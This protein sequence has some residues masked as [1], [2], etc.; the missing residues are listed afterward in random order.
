MTLLHRAHSPLVYSLHYLDHLAV[1]GICNILVFIVKYKLH[2]WL[3]A[4]L[5]LAFSFV[6]LSTFRTESVSQRCYF[7]SVVILVCSVYI[8]VFCYVHL[9]PLVSCHLPQ[10][11][12]FA[13]AF[14][15]EQMLSLATRFFP[16]LHQMILLF[17]Q[18]LADGTATQTL[19]VWC[20]WMFVYL[21]LGSL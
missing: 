9:S 17:S 19:T 7:H 18:Y 8:A 3:D 12:L 1:H 2:S 6:K 15:V 13:D 21:T 5:C 14:C 16:L 10:L 4:Y 11:F 20:L